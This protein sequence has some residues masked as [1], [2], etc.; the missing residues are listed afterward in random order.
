MESD[1][2]YGDFMVKLVII[3]SSMPCAKLDLYYITVHICC[4]N[5]PYSSF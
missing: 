1:T 3:D 5:G 4:L 2:F